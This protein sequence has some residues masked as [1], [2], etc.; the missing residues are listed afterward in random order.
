MNEK[1]NKKKCSMKKVI[2]S[3]LTTIVLSCVFTGCSNHNEVPDV[4]K[5]NKRRRKV[6]NENRLRK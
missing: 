3:L 6:G 1:F 5:K 4:V 2:T